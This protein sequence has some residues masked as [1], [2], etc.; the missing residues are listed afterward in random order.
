MTNERINILIASDINYAPYYGVMLTSLFENNKD[1]KFDVFLLTDDTWSIKETGRFETLCKKNN[2]NFYVRIIDDVEIS[3]SFPL[4][5]HLNRA[6]YYNLNV[7]NLLPESVHRVIYMDGDM[8]VNGDIRPLW[9]LELNDKVCAMVL[10]PMWR[11]DYVYQR[12]D[13]DKKYGYYNNGTTLYDLDKLRSLHFLERSVEFIGSH[14]QNLVMLDQD[15][16]NAL[17][18]DQILRMPIEYNFQVKLFWKSHW[19][20]YNSEFKEELIKAAQKP[21]IIHY[22]DRK[23]PWQL[24]YKGLPYNELW[25]KY[26]KLSDWTDIKQIGAPIN[27]YCKHLLKLVLKPSLIVSSFIP[28]IYEYLRR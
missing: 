21:I 14:K 12:L 18:H 16:T 2:S 17:L 3:D 4:S 7:A 27:K 22:S 15:V 1:S 28:N 13:Y 26:Y 25:N 24:I 10:A 6:T 19:D 8:I 9:E 20:E 5:A 11:E 23:K